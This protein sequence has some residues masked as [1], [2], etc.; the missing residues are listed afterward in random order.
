MS[1][2]NRA[3]QNRQFPHRHRRQ[4]HPSTS[5]AW[6]REAL[7]KRLATATFCLINT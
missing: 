4:N 1:W 6:C 5:P 2:I 7:Q 3:N